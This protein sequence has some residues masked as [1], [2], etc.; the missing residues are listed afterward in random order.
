M[1]E[2]QKNDIRKLR[3]D[4]FGYKLIAKELGISS[5]S[6]KSFCRR[7]ELFESKDQTLSAL[8]E[9]CGKELVN[10]PKKKKKRF[11]SDTCRQAWWNSHLNLVKRKAVYAY[12]CP[13]CQR[14][15]S[16]YGNAKRKYCSHQCYVAGRFGGARNE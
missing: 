2:E 14:E 6:V 11:C 10:I 12:I 16:V 3:E 15:F 4:G 13:V 1:T 9:Q 8:C 7:N 5:N